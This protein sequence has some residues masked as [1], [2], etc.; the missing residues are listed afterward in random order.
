VVRR[1]RDEGRD[2]HRDEDARLAA[3]DETA[4]ILAD[5]PDWPEWL[6]EVRGRTGED[7]LRDLG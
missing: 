6:R 3:V 1:T 4:G 2:R 5:V 7:R